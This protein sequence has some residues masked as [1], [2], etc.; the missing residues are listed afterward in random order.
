MV[1]LLLTPTRP[2]A[3]GRVLHVTPE[4][5]GWTYVGFDVHDLRDGQNLSQKTGGFETLL[6]FITGRGDVNVGGRQFG[7]V[8]G[9]MSVFE[10]PP[11]SVY[12]PAESEFT[13][14]AKG[15]LEV[16]LCRAPGKGGHEPR[17]IRPEQVG[18]LTRGVG[19]NVRHVRNVLPETEEAESLLVVECI[20]PGGHWSSYPPH[21]HDTDNLPHESQL[22]ETYYHRLDPP[23][24]YGMQRVYTDDRSLDVT[25]AVYDR[26][27]VL[28]P[29]GYHPVASPHGF[30]LYYLNVMAGPKRTWRIHNE[31]SHEF[32]VVT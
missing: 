29:K 8:G 12:A 14:T 20:T 16:A 10:G 22:E 30:T 25:M 23:Q 9:R 4:T 15:P 3:D 32:L 27:V 17:V 19:A 26:S 2:D 6:V 21:K 18:Q 7:T 28:V 31:P 11:W 5:A 13:V 1:D 24:G